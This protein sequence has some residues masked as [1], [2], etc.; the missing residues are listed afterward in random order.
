MVL[1]IAD[2]MEQWGQDALSEVEE[3]DEAKVHLKNVRD[4]KVD[5]TFDADMTSFSK[6]KTDAAAPAPA[7]AP[8]DTVGALASAGLKFSPGLA[9][10]F[11]L[12]LLSF[13]SHSNVCSCVQRVF[14]ACPPTHHCTPTG[15]HE[16]APPKS[17]AG[18]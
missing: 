2:V 6:G 18:V 15:L 7:P 12:P 13:P 14:A 5:Q 17:A 11:H 3:N 8:T 16:A 1:N 9:K 4:T 10:S